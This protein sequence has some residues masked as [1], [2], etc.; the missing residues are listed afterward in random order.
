MSVRE[1]KRSAAMELSSIAM[2]VLIAVAAVIYGVFTGRATGERLR[3]VARDVNDGKWQGW[4]VVASVGLV[5][6][7]SVLKPAIV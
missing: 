4:L 5:V 3:G 1:H 2:S 7:Y 6:A